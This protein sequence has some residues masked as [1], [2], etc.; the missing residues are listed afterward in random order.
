MA[1]IAMVGIAAAAAA[2]TAVG[3]A[4]AAVV[5]KGGVVEAV[6]HLP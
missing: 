2:H 5:R 3:T 6:H 1:R 4:V